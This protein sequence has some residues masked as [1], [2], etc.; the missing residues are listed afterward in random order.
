MIRNG[1]FWR[2]GDRGRRVVELVNLLVLGSIDEGKDHTKS[3]GSKRLYN[4]TVVLSTSEEVYK[5][6][7]TYKARG[8]RSGS[9]GYY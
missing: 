9:L 5:T 3:K 4:S 8:K 2:I 7:G 1:K 6:S